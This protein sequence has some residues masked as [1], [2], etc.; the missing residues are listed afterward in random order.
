MNATSS[1]PCENRRAIAQ[2]FAGRGTPAADGAMR[3]HVGA[4]AS[5]RRHYDRHLMLASLDPRGRRAKERIARGLGLRVAAPPPRRRGAWLALGAL[6]PAAAAVLL[7]APRAPDPDAFT[8][9]GAPAGGHEAAPAV[10]IYRVGRDGAVHLADGTI[11]ADD[12]L[13]FAYSNTARRPYLLIFGVDEHR[14]VYWFHP[15]WRVGAPPPAAVRASAGPGP[16][17]LPEAIRQHT[18]GRQLTIYALLSGQPLQ[19]DT[20]EAAIRRA[21]AAGPS[22][23]TFGAE[24]PVAIRS[25]AVRP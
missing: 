4:C 11:H 21:G 16:F 25:F 2:H 1:A 18:D 24:R 12:E 20:V 13:A 10:W 17:E 9:R 15:A 7:L 14:H 23:A 22:A 6:V 3:A 8:S 19:A 5:C